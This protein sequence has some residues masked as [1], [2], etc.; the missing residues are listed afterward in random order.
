[1][2]NPEDFTR[3][4]LAYEL[5]HPWGQFIVSA[6]AHSDYELV[7][8]REKTAPST[9]EKTN[10][11]ITVMLVGP[12]EDPVW[13]QQNHELPAGVYTRA[14]VS[15]PLTIARRGIQIVCSFMN[16]R[17]EMLQNKMKELAQAHGTDID[18]FEQGFETEDGVPV[19][20]FLS[21]RLGTDLIHK[22]YVPVI[23][24]T[25][26]GLKQQRAKKSPF[27]SFLFPNSFSNAQIAHTVADD[28]HNDFCTDHFDQLYGQLFK[29]S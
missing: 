20:E 10:E 27:K 4:P 5:V 3:L 7:P 17:D 26:E 16:R 6:A 19:A 2:T 22:L 13:Q 24:G 11:N 14:S 29:D 23:L 25:Y 15:A 21:E 28:I 1:M 8:L 18:N 9:D 12:E